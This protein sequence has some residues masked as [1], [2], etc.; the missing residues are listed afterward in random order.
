ML[1]G[2]HL[3]AQGARAQSTRLDVIANNLA[4]GSSTAF[5][6]GL[7]VFQA[8]R[9][10]DLE[11]GTGDEVP[12]NLNESTGGTTVAGVYRDDSPGALKQTSKTLDVAIIGEGYLKVAGGNGQ[13]FVTR[14]GSFLINPDG[15]LVLSGS[16]HKVLDEGGSPISFGNLNGE[17][18]IS[19]DGMITQVANGK[20]T[21]VGQLALVAPE[22]T[23]SL[24]SVGNG[25][26]QTD[27]TLSPVENGRLRQG[28][29]ENSG[30]EPVTE[31][32]SMIEASRGFETN[33]N[34]MK[35][36][37]DALARL[38]QSMPNR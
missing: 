18:N 27:A 15:E 11:N 29:L 2:L 10:Y 36:H 13:D 6:R 35:F 20:S 19:G 3:S 23:Q 28:F 8:H 16:G 9:P 33:I 4:N 34:M 17:I 5:K 25:L 26:Y 22:T 24:N 12:G 14:N 38:L 30:V 31:M 7:A 32:L 21:L 37:D 1:Y